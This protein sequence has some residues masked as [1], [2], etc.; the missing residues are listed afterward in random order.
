MHRRRLLTVAI[1][2]A[3]GVFVS[4]P[5]LGA[6]AGAAKG[7]F[8]Q[9]NLVSN[10]AV[11][12][13]IVDPQLKNPWG[14]SSSAGSPM[15][16]SDNN[17]GVTTLYNLTA[18]P[19]QKVA[20]TVTILP[21]KGSPMGSIGSPTGTVFNGSTDFHGDR[22]LFATED[23]TIA[24]WKPSDGIVAM[25]EADN[26]MVGAGAVYKGLA[27]GNNG[28]ANHLY[29]ANFRFGTVD[30]FNSDFSQAA[31]FTD[32]KIP[33]GY[34][35]FGIQVLGSV[36][37]VTYAMQNAEKHDDVAGQ[38]HG[39]V[40]AFDL[41][42]NLLDRLVSHGQL[43]SPWGLAIAP[44]SFGEFA[45]DLLVGNFGNGRINAFT[46][47]KG[48]FRGQLGSASGPIVIDG[49]WGLR[50]GNGGSGGDPNKIYFAA[51]INGESDGL[52]GS[53]EKAG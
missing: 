11:P 53:I 15:W 25:T 8:L 36:L 22:F 12:A 20:L 35:P 32:S 41:N 46:L 39:F 26:S 33:A 48:N 18:T 10:G 50:L 28:T 27:I 7:T 49:L 29:A 13:Q 14:L 1:A 5:T 30:V 31:S 21:G 17:A 6:S 45:G 34:A 40:D 51:G 4:L 37:Y 38:G 16:V 2:L 24:G 9:T 19:V 47:D 3:T 23:G 52:V 44:A 42:G 43:D